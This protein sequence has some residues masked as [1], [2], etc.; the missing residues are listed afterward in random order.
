M[1]A[2]QRGQYS[3][4]KKQTGAVLTVA[5]A[6]MFLLS[7]LG[8]AVMRTS[9]L[10]EKMAANSLHHDIAFQAAETLAEEAIS[11]TDNLTDAMNATDGSVKGNLT[12]PNTE[13][14]ATYVINYT[15]ESLPPGWSIQEGEGAYMAHR[16]IVD[17]T[18][19]IDAASTES[20]IIQGAYRIAPK[21]Q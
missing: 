13:I 6:I 4:A 15:G 1:N 14:D 16:F 3:F 11:D 18:G 9:S 20:R 19:G 8:L 21:A 10:E 2:I 17:T 7:I 12:H 5:L